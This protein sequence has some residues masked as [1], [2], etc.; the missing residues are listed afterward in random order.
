MKKKWWMT[1]GLV[2]AVV[3]LAA[4]QTNEK[5]STAA[6]QD[7]SWEKVEERG[8]LIVATS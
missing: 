6:K 1:L 3:G 5:D 7:A 8:R 2:A 4:C